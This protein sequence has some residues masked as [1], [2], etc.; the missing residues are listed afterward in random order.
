MRGRAFLVLLLAP[1]CSSGSASVADAADGSATEDTGVEVA[2]EDTLTDALTDTVA[3]TFAD[4]AGET[5]DP[6]TYGPYPA[7]PYGNNVGDVV[8]DLK[9]QGY[10]N[11]TADVVSTTRP[12]A[13]TSLDELRR[14]ARKPYAL[15][16]ASDFL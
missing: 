6:P 11:P 15:I 9:W 14:T 3:D 1:A 7:G 16:H 2:I 10:V 8:P 12:F 4:V 13:A 5:T